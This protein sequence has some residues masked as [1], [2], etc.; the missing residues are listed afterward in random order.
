M[1]SSFIF[2]FLGEVPWEK[3][4]AYHLHDTARWKDLN[5]KFVLQVYRDYVESGDEA[6]IRKMYPVVRTAFLCL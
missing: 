4:N 1:Y 5:T 2:F 3:V 6:F